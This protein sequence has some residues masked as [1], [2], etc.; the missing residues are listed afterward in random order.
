V[1]GP[2][3]VPTREYRGELHVACGVGEL[4]AAQPGLASGA[5]HA[6]VRIDAFGVTVPDIHLRALQADAAIFRVDH[7]DVECQRNAGLRTGTVYVGTDVGAVEAYRAI[8]RKV[9]ANLTLGGNGTATRA[10]CCRGCSCRA[11]AGR[12][13][14]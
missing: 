5:F 13:A 7:R 9:W 2:A 11:G 6:F 8:V 1:R 14:G 12:A 10:G 3:L 4:E